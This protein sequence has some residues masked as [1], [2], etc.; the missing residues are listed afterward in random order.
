MN[1]ATDYLIRSSNGRQVLV[2]RGA[3]PPTMTAGGGGWETVERP[4]RTAFVQWTNPV[5][6]QMT[7]PILFDGFAKN[8]NLESDISA[9]NQMKMSPGDLI[10]PPTLQIDGALP[11]KGATW[12]ITDIDWGTNVI[13][14][15]KDGRGYR[16][17][18]DAV[19]Q[20][21]Q[22]VAEDR[23]AFNGGVP[24]GATQP[25]TVKDGEDLQSVAKKHYGDAGQAKTIAKA[26]GIRDPKTVKAG[27]KLKIPPSTKPTTNPFAPPY[28]L[29]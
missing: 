1:L 8:R 6:Y 14:S 12:V 27:T 22:F 17:R 21:L 13:W 25:Y 15:A 19:L 4:R 3:D 24:K 29:K 10:P 16:L 9:V 11:V 28:W 2:L 7:V 18:Q 23:L 5:P 26:N 20:L